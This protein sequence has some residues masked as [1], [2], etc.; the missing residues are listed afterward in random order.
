MPIMT[1]LMGLW[2]A[3]CS[4]C[5][6]SDGPSESGAEASRPHSSESR[7]EASRLHS[8]V[9]IAVVWEKYWALHEYQE[10]IESE[11]EAPLTCWVSEDTPGVNVTVYVEE[12]GWRVDLVTDSLGGWQPWCVFRE[13]EIPSSNRDSMSKMVVT[14]SKAQIN[15]VCHPPNRS[16]QVKTLVRSVLS[17]PGFEK[18][19]SQHHEFREAK[20]KL[21]MSPS[22]PGYPYI[23][24]HV[25][26]VPR[27][28]I[29]VY[30][31]RTWRVEHEDFWYIRETP[32]ELDYR[33]IID[34]M[35]TEGIT[36]E[37]VFKGSKAGKAK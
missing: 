36:T 6:S 26:G 17:R 12:L 15:A 27:L 1:L 24:Y 28:G 7:V 32:Q 8:S 22:I 21:W 16:S 23:Y 29:I 19:L 37:Y 18:Y 33:H 31:E 34:R 10:S 14:I 4:S 25:E 5:S 35:Q 30:D 9:A 2:L 3:A 20:G 13:S 11:S